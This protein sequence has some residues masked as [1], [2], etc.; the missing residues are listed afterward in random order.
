MDHVVFFSAHDGTPTYRRVSSLDDAVL[1]VE[2]LRNVEQVEDVAVCALT[3]VPLTVRAYYKVEVAV[4]A[5]EVPEQQAPD[6]AAEAHPSE[7]HDER[8]P[9][10]DAELPPLV[11]VG[12]ASRNGSATDVRGLGFFAS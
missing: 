5:P 9:V 6:T 1:L 3:E 8:T 11:T 12:S 4:P 7:A 2:H 10:E